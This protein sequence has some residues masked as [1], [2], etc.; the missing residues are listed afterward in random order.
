MV[1]TKEDLAS[2]VGRAVGAST[3][4]V[5]E[6]I[7]E[8]CWSIRRSLKDGDSVCLSN[9]GNFETKKCAKR[10]GRN[11]HTKEAIPI[12]ERTQPVFRPA[13]SLKDAVIKANK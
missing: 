7:D 13:K 11:P 8:V 4:L 6:I 9:F 1:K 2:E 3:R 10:T 12:P 5:T